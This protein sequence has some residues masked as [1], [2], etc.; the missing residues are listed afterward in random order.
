MHD[1]DFRPLLERY[2]SQQLV[3][4]TRDRLKAAIIEPVA[5]LS[6]EFED[7]L[8]GRLVQDVGNDA[9]N[10][11]LLQMVLDLLWQH[12]EPRLL[13]QKAYDRVCG[14]EDLKIVLANLADRIYDGYAKQDKVKEF[15]QVL[16]SLVTL[17]EGKTPN[18]RRTATYNDIGEDNWREIVVPLSTKRL[19]KTDRD[20]TTNEETVEII[21]ETLIQSWQRLT[22]W[23]EDYRHELERIAEIETAAIKWDRNQRSKQ[24]LWSAKKLKE[25]QKF[26]KDRDLFRK[27]KPIV[28][29]FLLAS[30]QKQ[31]FDRAKL[32]GLGMILPPISLVYIQRELSI[33]SLRSQ[34]NNNR[35]YQ[36]DESNSKLNSAIEV[37]NSQVSTFQVPIFLVPTYTEPISQ[38]LISLG[39]ISHHWLIS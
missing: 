9:G 23:I 30:N 18:T 7:G 34:I 28:T 27:L 38:M 20:K 39:L 15:K 5:K 3:G 33:Q 8:V 29:D 1:D 12:Q 25:A 26:S 22:G 6:V 10:L 4:M 37:P 16:L 32:W 24:D 13:T 14:N 11:P 21:H 31:L 19:L 36:S 17:G 35:C 2:R